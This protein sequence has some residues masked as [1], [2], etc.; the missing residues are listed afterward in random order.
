MGCLRRGHLEDENG[1]SS[2]VSSFFEDE[3]EISS[4]EMRNR[5]NKQGYCSCCSEDG[6][7]YYGDSEFHREDSY[8]GANTAKKQ[9]DPS[10]LL[11]V[12]DV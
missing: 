5:A 3:E 1:Y 7:P 2:D 11:K 12:Q 9:L 6:Q 8:L 10:T 4:H